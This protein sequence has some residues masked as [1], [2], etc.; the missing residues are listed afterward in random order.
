MQFSL[1]AENILSVV[2]YR[3]FQ[4]EKNIEFSRFH[5]DCSGVEKKH[6]LVEYSANG[7]L[8]AQ[9]ILG[10]YSSESNSFGNQLGNWQV[11]LA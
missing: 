9:S 1:S 3:Y 4:F 10:S 8:T 2:H 6:I 7:P 11:V 5:R